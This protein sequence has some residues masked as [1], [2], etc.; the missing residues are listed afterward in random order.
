MDELPTVY[1]IFTP[2]TPA[3]LA[4]IERDDINTNLVNALR[5]P[6][7]QLVIYG[8]SGSGKSTIINKKLEQLFENQITTR[9][10][11]G[12]SFDQIVLDAFDQLSPYYSAETSNKNTSTKGAT[13]GATYTGIQTQISSLTATERA[14]KSA[15]ILPPQ[16]TLQ[17]LARFMGQS[18][19]CWILED[20]HKIEEA[21]RTKL[22]QAMKVFVDMATEYPDLKIIAIGAVD[23]AR[24]V[25]M[26]DNEMRTRVAEIH[27]PLMD[28]LELQDIILKGSKLMNL[29]FDSS[30]ISTISHYAAGLPSICHTLC[31]NICLHL[32]L[33]Q[34]SKK[35]LP[36]SK[37]ALQPAIKMYLDGA[38]DTLKMV[39]ET[40][41]KQTKVKKYNNAELIVKALSELPQE[42]ATRADIYK[43]ITR[44]ERDYP[45]GNLTKYLK[46]MCES[47][48][49]P[50]V[51]FS[52]S[53]GKYA[54]IDPLYRA[55]ATALYSSAQ[56][57]DNHQTI[58]WNLAIES[59]IKSFTT[60]ELTKSIIPRVQ[61]KNY[62]SNSH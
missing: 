17:N 31:L 6:G 3:N 34:P 5:T 44:N 32:D 4:F 56:A 59:F 38:S 49:P 1:Q 55:F 21:D 14:D 54:F 11:Q 51:R 25:V 19:S 22:S 16:L 52:D 8:H 62:F 61:H 47:A 9:C 48:V 42:G 12:M 60:K 13:L 45:Q 40:N 35:L 10:M 41:L 36:I 27:V 26:Y 57:S 39:F 24:Q 28:L 7:K 15:R 46:Q 33:E 20:F 29:K 30:L 43:H 37:S 23:S 2:A 18:K 50:L 58:D 53:S